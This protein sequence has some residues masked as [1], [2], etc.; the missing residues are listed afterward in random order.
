[1]DP[2]I[3]T[4]IPD[5]KNRLFRILIHYGYH[6]T[7]TSVFKMLAKLGSKTR[8]NNEDKEFKTKNYPEDGLKIDLED[9][10]SGR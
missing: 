9:K 1:M 10:N 3:E 8:V 4:I 6:N 5:L 2:V 7:Q